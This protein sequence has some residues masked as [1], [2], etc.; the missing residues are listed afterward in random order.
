VA[1]GENDGEGVGAK[2][3]DA[4]GAIVAPQ[5]FAVSSSLL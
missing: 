1:V 5:H 3:G 4:V 2:V